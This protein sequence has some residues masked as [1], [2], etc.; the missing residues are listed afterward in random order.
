MTSDRPDPGGTPFDLDMRRVRRSFERASHTY[1]EAAV[2]QDEVRERMLERLDLIRLEPKRILD[3]GCGTGPGSQALAG[4]YRGSHVIGLD[5]AHPMLLAGRKRQRLFRRWGLVCGD[6]SALPLASRSIDMIFCNLV[7]Q[8][9]PD[10]ELALREFRRVLAPGG[11][12]MFATFGPDTLR[13][14]RAAWS[15]ADGY[16]HVNAFLDMHDIGDA[17]LRARLAEPVMDVEHL[18]VNY[19]TARDLMRDLKAIG[20][21]NATAGR[22]R[23]LT[24]PHRLRAMETAYEQ[25]RQDGRLP[26]TYEVV[27]GHSWAPHTAAAADDGS[28]AIPVEAIGGR[29]GKSR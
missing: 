14:L 8:W 18:V 15:Q 20:A 27:Y 9:C 7:L 11:V 22:A 19:D 21:R 25:F 13:E 1:D 3:A 10:I 12:L 23:G 29:T 28:V 16:N 6:V 4:R 24:G 17:M 5:L 26:A 2:L